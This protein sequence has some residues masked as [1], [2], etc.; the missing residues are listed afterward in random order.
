MLSRFPRVSLFLLAS[1]LLPASPLAGQAT[2][3]AA[4]TLRAVAVTQDYEVRALPYAELRILSEAGDT[5]VVETDLEGVATARLAP[6]AYRV[7]S[8]RTVEIGN[9]R[10]DWA[11]P[12]ELAAAGTR[13]ELT[14]RNATTPTGPINTARPTRRVS[15]EAAIFEQVKSGV[16]T[17]L[18]EQGK[19]SGFLVDERGIVLTNAHVIQGSSEVRVQLDPET[20][21]RARILHVDRE[22][23]VAAL[24][25]PSSR[26]ARCYVLPVAN[27]AD[28]PLAVTGE[29]VLAIGSPL[30]QTGVLT[31]G[32]VSKLEE[33]A[34]ISD[35]NI[36]KGNSGGPM[37][38][39]EGRVIAINT[40]G[41]F[42]RVGPGISGSILI[43]QADETMRRANEAMALSSFEAPSD[44]LLPM[45]PAGAFPLDAI[46]AVASQPRFDV[47][48]Y[49]GSNGPFDFAIMTPPVVGW[50]QAQAAN[51]GLARRKQREARAGVSENEQSDPI[52]Q[53]YAWDEYVGERRPVVVFNVTPKVG[54]TRASG[55]AN[56][57]GAMAAGMAGTYYVANY[58]LE[59]KGDFNHMQLYR[60]G[61]EV[62]PIDR[63]RIPAVLDVREWNARGKDYAYQGIYVYDPAVFGPNE[64]GSQPRLEVRIVNTARIDQ[65]TVFPLAPR[66]VQAVW[67]DFEPMRAAAAP[68]AGRE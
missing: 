7:E 31:I 58:D 60:N 67:R 54:Q 52:Q 13:L 41:D 4:L 57:L 63:N 40:F 9:A 20:R 64:D 37:L 34:I 12:V 61:E 56:V 53:W 1:A 66:T 23:D 39:N 32:I 48:P 6:G 33:R 35:V 68:A 11:I 29:R 14:P 21:I 5:T 17:I 22:R 15:E 3:Q 36:N 25:I 50:R 65:P 24:L 30:N 51:A 42:T 43:T 16:F 28:G 8:V 18:G 47:R 2:T 46:K 55:W 26:C 49:T 10:L 59:F 19:G 38:N 45:A 44:S 62:V 27:P